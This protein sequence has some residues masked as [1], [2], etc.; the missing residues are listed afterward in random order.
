MTDDL[1]PPWLNDDSD[2]SDDNDLPDWLQNADDDSPQSPKK[3]GVTGAAALVAG[4]AAQFVDQSLAG[5]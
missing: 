4:A 5:W 3:S 2:D 1:L